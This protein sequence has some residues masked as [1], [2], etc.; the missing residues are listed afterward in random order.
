MTQ[1]PHA[2]ETMRRAIDEQSMHLGYNAAFREY[3]IEYVNSASLQTLLFCPFC[4]ARLPGSV[5]TEWFERVWA[6]GLE[7]ED[8]RVPEAMRSDQWWREAGL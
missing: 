3:S 7:P 2:C 1:L 6:M 5:R 4:G 8:P